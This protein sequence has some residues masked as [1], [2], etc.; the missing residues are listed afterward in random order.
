MKTIH[1]TFKI[2]LI[3]TLLT[4]LFGCQAQ[5]KTIVKTRVAIVFMS[6]HGTTAKV[7]QM[8]A[9][10]MKTQDITVVN[11]QNTPEID[12][13]NC[14]V[15]I[16][17]GSIHMGQIQKDIK[18]FCTNNQNLLMQKQVGL[19][20]SCMETGDKAIE[21]FKQAFPEPLRQHAKAT[22]F[23]GYELIFEKM[24]G[25]ERMMTKKITGEQVSVSR[26]NMEEIGKFAN[27]MVS[28]AVLN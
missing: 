23:T 8:I 5:T 6:K 27:T 15:V 26:I 11:L 17:G 12:I 4:N 20:V 18:S 25:M 13:S 7:A 14:E 1:L 19:F 28:V 9:D 3:M 10:S 2:L 16:I 24:N 22:A 21:Q